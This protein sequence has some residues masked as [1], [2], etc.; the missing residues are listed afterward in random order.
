MQTPHLKHRLYIGP[1][2]VQKLVHDGYY[3]CLTGPIDFQFPTD[4]PNAFFMKFIKRRNR[5][6]SAFPF[7]DQKITY[8]VLNPPF[9]S[10]ANPRPKR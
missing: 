8:T 7:D 3:N 2:N 9:I 6:A 4:K 1:D 10:R 5:K